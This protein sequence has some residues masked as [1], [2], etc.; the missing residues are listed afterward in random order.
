M[1]QQLLYSAD[2]IE[3]LGTLLISLTYSLIFFVIALEMADV[4]TPRC[5]A[6][7]ANGS[8]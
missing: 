5:R 6:T 4:D 3:T 2:I 7:S 8:P 1:P